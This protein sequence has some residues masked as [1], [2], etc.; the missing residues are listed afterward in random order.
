MLTAARLHERG[1]ALL[2]WE[3]LGGDVEAL[4]RL[5]RAVRAGRRTDFPGLATEAPL[6]F[7]PRQQWAQIL[8][9]DVCGATIADCACPPP[10]G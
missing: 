7:E 2:R 1:V 9:C 10:D 5:D 4:C 6:G 8:R 3:R